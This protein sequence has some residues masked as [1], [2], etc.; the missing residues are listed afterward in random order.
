[1]IST[2]NNDSNKNSTKQVYLKVKRKRNEGPV[3]VLVVD[4]ETSKRAKLNNKNNVQIKKVQE[5]KV[6]R[7]VET[8]DDEL[9]ETKPYNERIKDVHERLILL[10]RNKV[11]IKKEEKK[12]KSF[13]EK[14]M[15]L[16]NE[17][18][19]LSKA[20]RYKVVLKNRKT[21][22][23]K[24]YKDDN[25]EE[26]IIQVVDV[27]K[28]EEDGEDAN[29]NYGIPKVLNSKDIKKHSEDDI[30]CN[31]EPML[32]EFLNVSIDSNKKKK[33]EF[34]YDIYYNENLMEDDETD[35]KN[36]PEVEIAGLT[37][38]EGNQGNFIESESEDEYQE[39]DED[40]NEEDY[41]KN[42]Y[43]EEEDYDD[44]ISGDEN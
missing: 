5:Q 11:S 19:K 44:E 15:D 39:E 17:K 10:H 2:I 20:S 34:V 27:V 3:N 29:W 21:F 42:D 40:S 7:L 12:L 24:E 33:E 37:W 9:E 35:E 38:N 22:D 28:E 13:N 25:M 23:L 30:L 41:Y 36:N 6:F 4:R 1:M 43:P 16:Y 32:R 14:R 31:Y 8:F 18:V 26:D